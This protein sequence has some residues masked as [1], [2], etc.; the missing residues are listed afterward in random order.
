[1]LNAFGTPAVPRPA[2]TVILVRPQAGGIGVYLTR[3]SSRSRFMPGAFVFPGGAVDEADRSYA[4]AAGIGPL[5]GGAAPEIAVAALRELFE[6]AGILLARD[7]R[8]T[9]VPLAPGESAALRAELAAGDPFARIL[10]RRALSLDVAALAY[11]SNWITPENEPI[12]F[13]AHFFIAR[14]PSGQIAAADAVEVH[15]GVWLSAADALAA[16]A[17]DE[18]LLRFPTRKHLERL[19]RYD[20][21]ET[22]FAH[23]RSRSIAAVAPVT[24]EDG[25][26]AFDEEAW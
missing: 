21:I 20:D 15:D 19:A 4:R 26:F 16:S 11:Y 2:A 13:D 25:S 17:R 6:E 9:Q 1:M 22:L 3:R 14:A 5:P 8:G 12:R 18:L 10:E 23:A 7:E 24:R